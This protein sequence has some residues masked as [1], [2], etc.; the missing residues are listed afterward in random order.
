MFSS[1]ES[2]TVRSLS[3]LPQ[4]HDELDDE[5]TTAVS[6]ATLR[7][8]VS[9]SVE[10]TGTAP[11]SQSGIGPRAE[12]T[13]GRP[14]SPSKP[15]FLEKK[16]ATLVLAGTTPRRE[17]QDGEERTEID[18]RRPDDAPA[19]HDPPEV[20][21]VVSDVVPVPESNDA[22][23]PAPAAAVPAS[24][25]RPEDVAPVLR[26]PEARSVARSPRAHGRVA[27]WQ[28]LRCR[29]VALVLLVLAV[30]ARPWWWGVGD[31]HMRAQKQ[32]QEEEKPPAAPAARAPAAGKAAGG[33][34]SRS[35]GAR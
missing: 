8:L 9:R 16:G 34:A 25:V 6:V 29:L 18:A 15:A 27:L 24:A 26:T 3:A 7:D 20:S 5:K 13:F 33:P 31:L 11:R 14:L 19:A 1:R 17:K 23:V 30:Y 12:S 28:V 35:A 32:E 10:G 4:L 22:A 2:S 21:G